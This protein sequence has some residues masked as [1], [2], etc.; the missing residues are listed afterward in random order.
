M[1]EYLLNFK[2]HVPT[3]ATVLPP[4]M[5]P[6]DTLLPMHE[7]KCTGAVDREKILEVPQVLIRRGWARET[8]VCL[9]KRIFW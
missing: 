9:C 2:V 6:T 3:E 5:D 7:G 4:E 8:M 1:S